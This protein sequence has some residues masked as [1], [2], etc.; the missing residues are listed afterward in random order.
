M[1]LAEN[2]FCGGTIESSSDRRLKDDIQN[3]EDSVNKVQQLNGVSFK[4]K[5]NGNYTYGVIAQEVEKVLPYAVHANGEFKAVTYNA[6]IGLLIE[7]VKDQQ[8]QIDELKEKV[9]LHDKDII[10]TSSGFYKALHRVKSDLRQ[11]KGKL[12]MQRIN[13]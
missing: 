13:F 5:K 7:A 2:L 9:N 6:L 11:L 4:W 3:I 1:G 8:K 10:N 12:Q